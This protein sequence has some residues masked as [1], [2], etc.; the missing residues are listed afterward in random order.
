LTNELKLALEREQRI[1]KELEMQ[2]STI[3]GQVQ[4]RLAAIQ[5][6]FGVMSSQ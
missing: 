3:L 4:Q 6:Q 1:G 2:I 5:S